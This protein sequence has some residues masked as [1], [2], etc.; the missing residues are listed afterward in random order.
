MGNLT[1]RRRK[2]NIYNRDRRALFKR[3]LVELNGGKCT[4][5]GYNNCLKGLEFHHINPKKK[6][7]S[8][9]NFITNHKSLDHFGTVLEETKLCVLV[10]R[11]C[12]SEIHAGLIEVNG[13]K[14]KRKRK[15]RLS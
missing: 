7:F 10:C 1:E 13:K 2:N 3:K 14:L 8:I 6:N 15:K 12:H 5:C 9:T 11:N 4:M